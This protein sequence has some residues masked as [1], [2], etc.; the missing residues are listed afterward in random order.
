[1]LRQA[2]GGL[3]G[4]VLLGADRSLDP[5]RTEDLHEIERL[6]D[7]AAL[8]FTNSTAYQQQCEAEQTIREL[9]HEVQ[10]V[11]DETTAML[12][13]ELHD[14]IINISVRLNIQSLRMLRDR[15]ADA[16]LRAELE[17]LLESE[18]N[19]AETLR[20]I[21]ERIH[22]SGLDDPMGLPSLLRQQAERA[23]TIWPGECRLQVLGEQV[24]VAAQQQREAVRIVREALTN[25]VKH[26]DAT[27]ILV[28]L[29]YP[30][31]GG[32]AIT[33]TVEDDGRSGTQAQAKAGHRG[34]YG[35]YESARV[36]YGQLT[37]R[38][39]ETGG[40]R[41]VFAF[42]PWPLDVLPPGHNPESRG[43]GELQHEPAI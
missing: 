1:V 27:T 21:C 3:L 36:A 8:A 34:I 35:M 26:A 33:I 9:Y 30:E 37:F 42:P 31:R 7:A 11:Q 5:Y 2:Q 38:R 18:Q 16:A 6:L 25:A 20:V 40:M 41:V 10:R 13:R 4:F 43:T 32:D 22:P 17:S 28:T 14:E 24:L 12:A 39:R 19:V 23:E 15:T 29:R